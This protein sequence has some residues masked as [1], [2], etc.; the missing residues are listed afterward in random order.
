[1]ETNRIVPNCTRLMAAGCFLL[2]IGR[3]LSALTREAR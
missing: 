3:A 1:M 2:A